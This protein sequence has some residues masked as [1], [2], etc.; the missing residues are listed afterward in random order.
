MLTNTRLDYFVSKS[1]YNTILQVIIAT[2][3]LHV[4]QVIDGKEV[5][6]ALFE[7]AID[8]VGTIFG[9]LS[10]SSEAKEGEGLLNS[11]LPDIF[12]YGYM[13]PVCDRTVGLEDLEGSDG[14]SHSHGAAKS[15]WE[16]WIQ[17]AKV[18]KEEILGM[19][20][21]RLK[22]CIEDTHI[23]PLLASFFICLCVY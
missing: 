6:P 9:K 16:A 15:L 13:L 19:I 18:A 17:S 11:L 23:H 1:G 22:M 7:I 3:G 4:K 5:R 8:F 20:K 2:F 10:S 14:L 21:M 12:L